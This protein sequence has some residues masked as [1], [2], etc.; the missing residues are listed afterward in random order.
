MIEKLKM[1]SHELS[2]ID[3][4]E[5]SIGSFS[6]SPIPNGALPSA[7][8]ATLK[9]IVSLWYIM[10]LWY[11]ASHNAGSHRNSQSHKKITRAI[12]NL[13]SV[14]CLLV[15][16][17]VGVEAQVVSDDSLPQNSVITVD[18]NVFNISGGTVAG[19]NL[20]HS[21]EQFSLLTGDTAFFN[22]AASIQNIISR[23]TGSSR[24]AIDGLIK[25]NGTANLFLLNPNGIIFGNNAAL[26][27]GGSFVASTADSINFADDTE[28][29][30]TNP[31]ALLTVNIPVGLQYGDRPGDIEVRGTGNNLSIDPDA[32]TVDRQHRPVG[33]E[34]DSDRT[35][36][37]IGG[38][39]NLI[40]GNVSTAGGSIAIGSV[41]SGLVELTIDDSGWNFDYD[42]PS[43]FQDISLSQSASIEAS[44][45]GGGNVRLQGR[46]ISIIDGSA[47][48][49]DTLGNNRGNELSIR[50]SE[51]VEISGSSANSFFVSRLSTD[52]NSGAAGDGGDLLLNSD[53]LTVA[54]GGQIN[55]ATF[56]TGKGGNLIIRANEIELIGESASTGFASG[57]FAQPDFGQTGDGGNLTI[58][59]NSLLIADGAQI[60]TTTFGTGSGGNLS[61]T[62]E[63]V[64]L[65]GFSASS[66]SIIAVNAE[67]EGNGSNL[68]LDTNSLFIAD[69]AQIAATT[70]GTGNSGELEI[71][72]NKIELVGGAP[73]FDSSGIFAN[74]ERNSMGN[75][76]GINVTTQLLQIS[77]GAQI[78]STTFGVG[79]TGDIIVQADRIELTGTSPGTSPSG[80][81]ANVLIPPGT[82]QVDSEVTG[83]IIIDTNELE[84][85]AGAQIS[86]TTISFRDAGDLN[87]RAERSISLDGTSRGGSSGVF[88]NA[89]AADGSGG[90]LNIITQQLNLSNNATIS[91]SN[92]PSNP[93]SNI[94]SGRGA[95]GNLSIAAERINLFRG[96]TLTADTLAGNRGNIEIQTDLLFLDGGSISTNAQQEASG[97]NIIVNADNGFI[98]TAPQSNSDITA[99]AVFG[100]GGRVDLNVLE[101]IGIEPRLQLTPLSDIT[102]SSEFGIGGNIVLNTQALNIERDLPRLPNNFVAPDFLQGCQNGQ[103]KNRDRFVN[104]GQGGLR[105]QPQDL[106]DSDDPLDDIETPEWLIDEEAT[107]T[108]SNDDSQ[109]ILEAE[110]WI[111]NRRGKVELV[112]NQQS[113][114]LISSQFFCGSE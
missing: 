75:S 72:A 29:S 99:N 52:V 87:I 34:V 28:F 89:L 98:V 37:L 59:T 4:K 18:G 107:T 13:L 77:D 41:S 35:L 10:P 62:A 23:V 25:T 74:V 85:F 38:N 102:A 60:S 80:I 27:I 43:D 3:N 48:L 1:Q 81:F 24:S 94:A 26:D 105:S 73:E 16:I 58:D 108:D 65:I 64:E 111:I 100:A 71:R 17:Q 53:R 91:V 20:F 9:D 22:N 97:G 33:L 66:P 36:G 7:P 19:D 44:G 50:A 83:N 14:F 68:L 42:R 51:A 76:A 32:F 31:E 5:L 11:T 30:A 8:S 103:N 79:N 69:G 70:F 15:G 86:T 84:V 54:R 46:N 110:D 104:I 6:Q 92:F 39:V 113:P 112:M 101:I 12:R 67:A 63:T 55:V 93:N 45:E 57:L 56:G 88:A 78:S 106:L 109:E 90:D 2:F 49:A 61:L 96:A 82:T 21:F 47:I 114:D 95:A 40:G